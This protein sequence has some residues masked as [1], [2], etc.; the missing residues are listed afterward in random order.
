LLGHSLYF[1]SKDVGKPVQFVPPAF[2]L[3]DITQIP[4]FRSFNAKDYGC[5]LWW[6]EYGGRLDTVHQTEEIKWEFWKVVYGVWNHI[7]NSGEFPEAETLTLEWVGM[8]PG[9]RESRRFEGDYIL[10]AAGHC[11][12]AGV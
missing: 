5:R 4:R 1:Y 3:K 11:G 10:K 9:K 8:I 2:A 12:A 7:K 6:I